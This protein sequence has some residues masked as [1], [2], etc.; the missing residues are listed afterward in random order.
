M[1]I[2][3]LHTHFT[4]LI[5]SGAAISIIPK[6]SSDVQDPWQ[7]LKAANGSVIKTYGSETCKVLL[8]Q[9]L[10]LWHKFVK[11]DVTQPILGA[12]FLSEHRML[13][14]MN[15]MTLFHEDTGTIIFGNKANARI[16]AIT[17]LH[18]KEA[19]ELLRKYPVEFKEGEIMP[20]PHPD[21]PFMEIKTDGPLPM[22]RPRRM[23]P[24]MQNLAKDYIFDLLQRQRVEESTAPIATP[25]H[26]VPKADGTWR[27]CGDFRKLNKATIPVTYS[28]PFISDATGN[29]AGMQIFSKLDLKAAFEH[30]QIHPDDVDKTTITTPFGSFKF[31]F[32]CYGLKNASQVFQMYIDRV[33][34]N[35][36]RKDDNGVVHKLNIFCYVDDILLSSPDIE[37][38]KKDL[39]T[40]FKRLSEFHLKINSKKC[41]FFQTEL[42]FLG[43]LFCRDGVKPTEAKVE[44][45][46]NYQRPATLGGLKKFLG[47]VNFYHKYI[48]DAAGVMNPL[49]K[50]LCGYKKTKRHN[51]VDWNNK[52]TIEAFEKTKRALA[53]SAMLAYPRADCEIGL[54]TDASDQSVA[55]VLTQRSKD[56]YWEPLGFFSKSL[57]KREKMSSTFHKE[58]TGVFKSLK[59]FQSSLQGFSFTIYTDCKTIGKAMEKNSKLHSDS[60]IKMLNY[61]ST[62]D[63]PIK[64]IPGG[65]NT[66]AD[67]LSRPKL[68]ASHVWLDEPIE[69]RMFKDEQKRCPDLK[70]L[71]EGNHGLTMDVREIDGI[72]YDTL[73]GLNR[74]IVP[75]AL[76]RKIFDQ[77]HN[78]GH[79]GPKRTL[80]LIRTRFIWPGMNKEVRDWAK[81]CINCQKTKITRYNRP[82]LNP[83][84]PPKYKFEQINVDLAGPLVMSQGYKY[85]LVVIDRYSLFPEAIP[86]KDASCQTVLDA[87]VLHIFGRWGVP[88]SL[89]TDRGGC[90]IANDFRD[91]MKVFGISHQFTCSYN[92]KS[93]GLCERQNRVIKDS[94]RAALCNGNP[95]NW[96]QR[97][98]MCL[99]AIRN[100]YSK[101]INTCPS[102]VVYGSATRLPGD[103]ME[104]PDEIVMEPSLYAQN[105]RQDLLQIRPVGPTFKA[106][107]GYTEPELE[108]CTHVFIKDMHKKH[109]LMPNY[110]GPFKVLKKYP[111]YFTIQFDKKTDNVALHRIKAAHILPNKADEPGL[112]IRPYDHEF[113]T[114]GNYNR[115]QTMSAPAV[116]LPQHSS[117]PVIAQMPES[118]N[119]PSIPT[120]ILVQPAEEVVIDQNS[121]NNLADNPISN[122][123]DV[124]SDVVGNT[125]EN[126]ILQMPNQDARNLPNVRNPPALKP[127]ISLVPN[128]ERLRNSFRISN[129]NSPQNAANQSHMNP[130]GSNES[131]QNR[132]TYSNLLRRLQNYNKPGSIET[133]VHSKLRS[134]KK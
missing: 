78:L 103:I 12:D 124:I 92:P 86:I 118:D 121:Q 111:K 66:I 24:I 64:H 110:L 29:M 11:A 89:T 98:G 22:Y 134:G 117:V 101:Q 5:D 35:L 133:S 97:L 37:S 125:P 6:N 43:H 122:Q 130:I 48:H 41:Q 8:N 71:R 94:L 17:P 28:L 84:S 38:H 33:L 56:G 80:D 36:S 75:T 90:F 10:P 21:A 30:L 104:P 102:Q 69:Q 61:I 15:K 82:E 7:T 26:A 20:P 3:C 47:M 1:K 13:V 114:R 44:A 95:S 73:H 123:S 91:A 51:K 23:N 2:K 96:A 99:L 83:I 60:E 113:P 45:I 42:E 85:L 105:L 40:L 127:K 129:P 55:G 119:E 72:L 27:F 9:D 128:K 49:H 4:F 16:H 81:S 116:Q 14:N 93:N 68:Q 31:R 52:E 46:L 18:C 77:V 70:Y 54:Y 39:E 67:L 88:R 62:Y 108:N 25:L 57:N 112:D 79:V 109:G 59:F 63:A 50:A 74:A 53:N 115:L 65:E 58:L 76:R 107:L 106:K 32:A 100:S 120:T 87:L 126:N 131:P 19:Q 132:S 34:R